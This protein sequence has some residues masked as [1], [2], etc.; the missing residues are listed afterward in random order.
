MRSQALYNTLLECP[1]LI[2]S[3][4]E[5]QQTILIAMSIKKTLVSLSIPIAVADLMLDYTLPQDALLKARMKKLLSTAE[6]KTKEAAVELT[7]TPPAPVVFHTMEPL[8]KVES[9]LSSQPEANGKDG[10]RQAVKSAFCVV[11]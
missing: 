11:I 1:A 10:T 6:V 2:P 3:L 9:V 8:K 7:Q 5:A 4:D